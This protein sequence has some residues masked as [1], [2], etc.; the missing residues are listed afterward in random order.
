MQY[1]HTIYIYI[2]IYIIYI[3]IKFYLLYFYQLMLF[4]CG[5]M[6][7][8]FMNGGTELTMISSQT[9]EYPEHLQIVCVFIII[10]II[11]IIIMGCY[12]MV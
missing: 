2:I 7:D 5:S 6:S 1:I 9:Q 12:F 4:S 11:I 3:T 10:I 8:S